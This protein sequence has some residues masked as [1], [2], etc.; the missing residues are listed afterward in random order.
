MA[1][2][3]C[4]AVSLR[5]CSATVSDLGIFEVSTYKKAH[6]NF[7]SI[8]GHFFMETTMSVGDPQKLWSLRRAFVRRHSIRIREELDS[9]VSS[10]FRL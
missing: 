3:R 4:M 7:G 5:S 2:C 6:R 10:G 8:L 9:G 1:L